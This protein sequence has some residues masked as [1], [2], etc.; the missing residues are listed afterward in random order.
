MD[1]AMPAIGAVRLDPELAIIAA[2]DSALRA[3]RASLIAEHP[4][5][6]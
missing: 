1:S 4:D 2:L 3:C 5:A 6:V